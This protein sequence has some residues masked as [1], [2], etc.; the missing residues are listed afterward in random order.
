MVLIRQDYS[1][2][3][4]AVVSGLVGPFSPS[5]AITTLPV[6]PARPPSPTVSQVTSSSVSISFALFI[7]FSTFF[8][9]FFRVMND[10]L[11]LSCIFWTETHN[12]ALL[13][14]PTV[15]TMWGVVTRI[16]I[17][18]EPEDSLLFTQCNTTFCTNGAFPPTKADRRRQARQL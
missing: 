11:C 1:C 5:L 16:Q 9:S 13:T 12:Q 15:N 18:V 14:W 4:A 17:V 3:V 7:I 6:A 2:A 8:P 10:A